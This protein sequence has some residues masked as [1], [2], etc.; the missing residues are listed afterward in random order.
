MIESTAANFPLWLAPL[1]CRVM[2]IT[3]DV[4]DYGEKVEHALKKAGVRAEFRHHKDRISKQIKQAEEEKIPFQLVIGKEEKE[5]GTVAIRYHGI[6]N[7]PPGP[8]VSL[9][10]ARTVALISQS[11]AKSGD[12]PHVEPTVDNMN[13]YWDGM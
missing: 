6:G 11:I 10:L 13:D 12:A 8:K 4:A 2:C 1:Q 3:D 7:V 9:D 5:T